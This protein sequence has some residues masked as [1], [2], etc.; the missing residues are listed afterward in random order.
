MGRDCRADN[1]ILYH[2]SIYHRA[3][4]S[5]P[6]PVVTTGR[7]ELLEHGQRRSI[8]RSRRN[9][10]G[11]TGRKGQRTLLAIPPGQKDFPGTMGRTEQQTESESSCYLPSY[12]NV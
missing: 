4:L 10:Y 7:M 12:A 11:T 1:T 2:L 9:V 5:Q 8:S 3:Q 6:L